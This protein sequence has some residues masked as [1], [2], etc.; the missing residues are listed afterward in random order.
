MNFCSS[1]KTCLV[2]LTEHEHIVI[3]WLKCMCLQMSAEPRYLCLRMV[4]GLRYICLQMV[5]SLR[6][7]CLQ[8]A[9]GLGSYLQ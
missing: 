5:A 7:M 2:G 4:A 3:A 1:V 6:L 8:M 9:A